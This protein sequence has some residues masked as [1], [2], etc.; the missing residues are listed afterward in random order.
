MLI[1]HLCNT[2]DLRAYPEKLDT[3]SMVK[4]GGTTDKIRWS[5]YI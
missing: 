4:V 1:G 2:M 5:I 3:W